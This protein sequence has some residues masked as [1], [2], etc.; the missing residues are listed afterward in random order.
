MRYAIRLI[1]L[2]LL[3]AFL[4][5]AGL[6]SSQAADDENGQGWM[7]FKES[8][9]HIAFDVRVNGQAASAIFDT[10][11]DA[12]VIS[13]G[14]AR[15]AEINLNRGD[16]IRLVGIHGQGT[17]P[18]SRRFTLE[19]AG[20]EV[21]LDRVPVAPAPGFDVVFGRPM[22]ESS[23]VQIDYP[24]QRI[25]FIRRDA[26]EFEGNVELRNT[27]RGAPMVRA[28]ILDA[29]L[30][31]LLDTGNAG[32]TVLKRKVVRHRD[33]EQFEVQGVTGN[34]TGAF[35]TAELHLLQIPG[36]KLGPY[37]FDSLLASYNAESNDGFDGQESRTGSRLNSDRSPY[38]GI[39]G[40]EVLRNFMV[41]MDL[42][43]KQVQ[44]RVAD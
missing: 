11:A 31:M 26:V 36:F 7:P 3:A 10:G 42:K 15:R 8:N 18:T 27:R 20:Q 30:W 4:V 17:I 2:S 24:N 1:E 29:D 37:E 39:L 21:E 44:I 38:D 34:A 32:P 40:Y 33:L 13:E 41:T 19:M 12:S 23:V 14:L 25:R 43:D 5:V 9:G 35:T 6:S 16:S 28:R 22:A